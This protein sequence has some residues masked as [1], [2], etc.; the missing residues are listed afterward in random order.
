[1]RRRGLQDDEPTDTPEIADNIEGS[2]VEGDESLLDDA[3]PETE[4]EKEEPEIS[5][6]DIDTESDIDDDTSE[7]EKR[8]E[9]LGIEDGEDGKDIIDDALSDL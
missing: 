9:D 1:M 4:E 7:E 2:K 8:T 3:T 5:A 6:D